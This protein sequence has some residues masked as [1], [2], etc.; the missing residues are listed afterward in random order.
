MATTKTAENI[1]EKEIEVR[2]S[3]PIAELIN[4]IN[5]LLSEKIPVKIALVS[6]TTGDVGFI[7][8]LNDLGITREV[9]HSHPFYRSHL[10]TN[11]LGQMLL[12]GN[13]E[14]FCNRVMGKG[15]DALVKSYNHKDFG[16]R[17][18]GADILFFQFHISLLYRLLNESISQEI[19]D[20]VAKITISCPKKV[21]REDECPG[22]TT[23]SDDK[24]LRLIVPKMN[25]VRLCFQKAIGVIL[26]CLNIKNK[27][28]FISSNL[29]NYEIQIKDQ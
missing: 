23:F 12:M 16:L 17:T 26:E 13:L 1:T 20:E 27:E 18:K 7:A 2:P 4:S 15:Y 6:D 21:K 19:A 25:D 22:I 8:S 24:S 11:L 28:I 29:F 3:S 10:F 5:R 14:L 9:F